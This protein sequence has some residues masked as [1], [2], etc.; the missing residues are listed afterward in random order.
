MAKVRE[1]KK[2]R[3]DAETESLRD[4]LAALRDSEERFR[5]VVNS[6]NE[7]I[8]VYDRKLLVTAGLPA[9]P[10]SASTRSRTPISGRMTSRASGR[11][12]NL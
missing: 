2:Q 7:G 8:L 3:E 1:A 5:A 6:A 4:A 12:S 10:R 11:S 9:T